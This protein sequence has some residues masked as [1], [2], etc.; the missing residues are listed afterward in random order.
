MMRSGPEQAGALVSVPRRVGRC[1]SLPVRHLGTLRSNAEAA[2]TPGGCRATIRTGAESDRG[3]TGRPGVRHV[4]ANSLCSSRSQSG[5][6]VGSTFGRSA[7][8][9]IGRPC[10]DS[11]EEPCRHESCVTRAEPAGERMASEIFPIPTSSVPMV[12]SVHGS[13]VRRIGPQTTW[14]GCSIS[15]CWAHESAAQRQCATPRTPAPLPRCRSS[16]FAAAPA[17]PFETLVTR[18]RSAAWSQ[19]W[20]RPAMR[21]RTC[22]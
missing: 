5:I 17:L 16:S 2:Q 6:G 18:G 22:P 19:R 15:S 3:A 21:R 1:P 7:P 11:L 4:A 14:T 20:E 12:V 8:I 9:P 13:P 10:A